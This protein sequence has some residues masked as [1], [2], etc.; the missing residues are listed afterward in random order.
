[1][2]QITYMNCTTGEVT[3]N[4]SKAMEWYRTGAQIDLIDWSD[5]L[6]CWVTRGSWVH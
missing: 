3:E 1:M 5:T 6:N 4:H 2:K